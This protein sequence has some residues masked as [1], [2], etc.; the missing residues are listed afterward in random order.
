[1]AR[2]RRQPRQDDSAAVELARRLGTLLSE[3][4]LSE[5][6]V[7]VGEVRIRLQRGGGAA[8]A[9]L[10]PAVASSERATAA[11]PA[12][13]E[14]ASGVTIEAPMVGTFY[15]ASSPT[16]EPYVSEGDLVKEGQILCIIE[17]M[18]LM[19]EVETRAAGRIAKILADNG[20][21][22]EYG[23]PLFLIEPPR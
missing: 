13:A 16:A 22:V 11:A 3:L 7:A 17:A 20:Q 15:R 18:K 6:D 5:I 10:A 21:A 4:G 1:M 14:S 23:Q 19:N 12:D 9:A 8:L 2:G